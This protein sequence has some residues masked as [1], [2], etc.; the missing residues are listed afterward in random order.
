MA[1]DWDELATALKVVVLVAVPVLAVL[2][3]AFAAR[4]ERSLYFTSLLALLA[5]VAF[6]VGLWL[7]AQIFNREPSPAAFLAW[8]GSPACSPM[9]G[10]GVWCCLPPWP[11]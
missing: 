3:A 1:Q 6:V 2:A 4:R 8:P 10:A 11:S 9:P 5:V 7:L